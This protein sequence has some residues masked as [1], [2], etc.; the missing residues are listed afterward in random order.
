MVDI[1]SI[2]AAIVGLKNAAEIARAMKDLHNQTD[3]QTRVIDLQSAILAAQSDALS[4]QSEQSLMIQKIRD[5]QEEVSRVK[6][7]DETRQRYQLIAPWEG[8]YV[9]ALKESSKGS[10]PP[11]WICPHCYED[12]RKSILHDTDKLDRRIRWIIKCPRCS[13]ES[14]KKSSSERKYTVSS[15]S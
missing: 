10:E 3:I 7:W 9:Y 4:A 15:G 11:H 1:P 8:C 12:G 6:A 14:E 2:T 13:F 5:L